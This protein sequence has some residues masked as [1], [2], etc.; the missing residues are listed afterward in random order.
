MRA[1]DEHICVGDYHKMNENLCIMT[2]NMS[3]CKPRQAH[4][5]VLIQCCFVATGMFA[6]SSPAA[7]FGINALGVL[8]ESIMP[9][10]FATG[11]FVVLC[12]NAALTKAASLVLRNL[13]MYTKSSTWI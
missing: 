4:K 11:A 7:R 8:D 10:R 13:S 3:L 2:R 9:C 6:Y 12:A 1:G 5:L